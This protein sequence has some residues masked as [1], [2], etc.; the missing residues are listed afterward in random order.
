MGIFRIARIAIF[1]VLAVI[2]FGGAAS[3]AADGGGKVV[4]IVLGVIFLLIAFGG[5]RGGS[6]GQGGG[7]T[8]M[9]AKEKCPGSGSMGNPCLPDTRGGMMDPFGINT[10][11]RSYPYANCPFCG[12]AHVPATPGSLIMAEHYRN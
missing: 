6:G 2:C 12:Q 5:S 4:G 10:D 3:S 1:V 8:T 9:P 7:Q 11:P